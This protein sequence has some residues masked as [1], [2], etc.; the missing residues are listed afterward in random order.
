MTSQYQRDSQT[1]VGYGNTP[2]CSLE[3]VHET[4]WQL[5]MWFAS[6]EKV[7]S[8]VCLFIV[9]WDVVNN[10]ELSTKE[11]EE[12]ITTMIQMI[13]N[14]GAN[15]TNYSMILNNYKNCRYNNDQANQ[16]IRH[17]LV[18]NSWAELENCGLKVSSTVSD[19]LTRCSPS[20]RGYL[21]RMII[22]R[23]RS[24]QPFAHV[25][26]ENAMFKNQTSNLKKE[27]SQDDQESL[28]R[29]NEKLRAQITDLI[30]ENS[31]QQVALGNLT[32]LSWND[33]DPNNS[34]KLIRDITDLQDMLSDFTMVQGND[35]KINNEA[36]TAL[37]EKWD[38]KVNNPGSRTNLVLGFL[39]QRV[40]IDTIMTAADKY[41]NGNFTNQDSDLEMDLIN[42]TANLIYCTE[43]LR[44]KRKGD[45]DITKITPIKIRQN[46][47]SALSCRGLPVDHTLIKDTAKKLLE[48]M[49]LYRE[50]VD[51]ETK[52]ELDEQAIQIT[53]KVI[54]IFY[55]RL[56]TQAS[57]PTYQFFD[58]GQP[59]EPRLMQGA[60]GNDEIRKLEVEACGFPCIG[61]F[62]SDKLNSKIFM[63]AQVITRPKQ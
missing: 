13:E 51:E 22:S 48:E 11:F 19:Q 10:A 27:N 41:F 39:L 23:I 63:K 47:Y 38:C 21:R 29:E 25:L 46:V 35:Y 58:A 4:N 7:E 43:S 45:D 59:V 42:A 8:Y 44:D 34:K 36:A 16:T 2:S 54:H 5:F 14:L 31:Q 28:K 6:L 50:V 1:S 57:E 56:K 9:S 18:R 37:L 30:K 62:S 61:I 55:F 53:H 52:D 3:K 49:N 15:Y 60:F 32:N 33:D 12:E 26:K 20:Q 17:S 40:A 24:F